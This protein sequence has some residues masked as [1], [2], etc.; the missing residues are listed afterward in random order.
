MV[1]MLK[2]A[3]K[4]YLNKAARTYVTTPSCTLPINNNGIK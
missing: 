4:W 1:S 2:R 3:V